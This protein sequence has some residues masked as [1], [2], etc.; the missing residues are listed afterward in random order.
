MTVRKD[1]ADAIRDELRDPRIVRPMADIV[2]EML[3]LYR[4]GCGWPDGTSDEWYAAIY[5]LVECGYLVLE[6]GAL[7]RRDKNS[8]DTSTPSNQK[9]MQ[10]DL[11]D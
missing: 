1:L 10:L 5:S 11:F 9:P 6:R 4:Y 7:V 2:K 3:V 8:L